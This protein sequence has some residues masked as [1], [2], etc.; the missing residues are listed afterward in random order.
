M[1]NILLYQALAFVILLC[2]SAFFSGSE[3]ALTS[4]TA[5]RVRKLGPTES[6]PLR[7]WLENPNK[8][9]AILLVG[10]NVVNIVTAFLAERLTLAL[11]FPQSQ[12]MLHAQATAVAAAV[13]TFIILVFGEF[14]PKAF[15][16][17]HAERISVLVI[18]PVQWVYVILFPVIWLAQASAG[19]LF[20]LLR[21][22]GRKEVTLLTEDEMRTLIDVSEEEGVIEDQEREM[23]HSIIDFGD[24]YAR[25]IMTPRTFIQAIEINS[26]LS[27][28]IQLCRESGHSRIPVYQDSVDHI[29]GILHVKDLLNFL[30]DGG[31][32]FSIRGVMR[33][34]H[35]IPETKRIMELL[36]EL[37]TRKTH[38]AI[39]LDEYGG[40]AGL[41]TFE[42][43]LEEIVGEI[44]DEYDLEEAPMIEPAPGGGWLVDARLNLEEF[45]EQV[46]RKFDPLD[47]D[48]VGGYVSS[49][50]GHI[51]LVGEEITHPPFAWKILSGDDRRVT[52][53]MARSVEQEEP[54]D[55]EN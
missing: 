41:V 3:T 39:V 6:N 9:L 15:C 10:N 38:V 33:E 49:L 13:T 28:A 16:R 52:K 50:F 25:E 44:Q 5:W 17:R 42:D 24:T 19:I 37:Q 2:L 4:M 21:Q 7:D 40:T 53:I 48:T 31:G 26:G 11:F 14:F 43:I 45:Q 34:P 27:E 8:Y 46:E 36:R 12:H 35:F 18:R 47:C 32:T 51:P 23:I 20:F 1:E 55:E 22:G 29:V 54:T 30:A